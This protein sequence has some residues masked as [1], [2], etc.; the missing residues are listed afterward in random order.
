M[1]DAPLK[2]Q[3]KYEFGEED[4]CNL[5]QRYSA[6]QP[7]AF[8][9]L[10]H[11]LLMLMAE[12]LL[13]LVVVEIRYTAPQVLAFLRE[14]AQSP[15][16]KVDWNALVKNTTTGITNARECQ[17]L[18]RHLAYR[19]PFPEKMEEQGDQPLVSSQRFC[20]LGIWCSWKFMRV[21]A[22]IDALFI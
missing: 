17:I 9:F 19:Q 22:L 15:G 6:F 5:F 1:A 14:V 7:L 12:N 10:A 13:I 2:K 3:K 4:V 18:W 20:A 16:V 8:N 21:N 11:Y